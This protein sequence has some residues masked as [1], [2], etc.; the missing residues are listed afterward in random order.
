M[1]LYLQLHWTSRRPSVIETTKAT[2]KLAFGWKAAKGWMG[3]EVQFGSRGT[4]IHF[5]HQFVVGG[6]DFDL[7]IVDPLEREHGSLFEFFLVNRG[8]VTINSVTTLIGDC[9]FHSILFLIVN[10]MSSFLGLQ[11]AQGNFCVVGIIEVFFN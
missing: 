9:H 1:L 8:T 4:E 5:W 6:G 3:V 10:W 11:K 7:D 2:S